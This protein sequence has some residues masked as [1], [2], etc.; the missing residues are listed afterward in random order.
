MEKAL[1]KFRVLVPGAVRT[2]LLPLRNDDLKIGIFWKN[3][4]FSY[5]L[6]QGAKVQ[7]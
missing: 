5:V 3:I 4:N 7:S 6:L 2:N 1:E